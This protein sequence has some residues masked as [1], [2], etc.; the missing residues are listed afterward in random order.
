MAC[1]V[2]DNGLE[3]VM[4]LVSEQGF[5][6][7]PEAVR[8][9][10]NEAMRIERERHL[11][12]GAW[13]R[14]DERR[15]HANGYKAKT[16]RSRIGELALA[17]PQVRDSSFYPSSLERGLRSERALKLAVAEMYVTGVSTRK[18][19]RITETL[20]GFEV[21]SSEVSRCTALLDG[22]L[23][24]WRQRRFDCAYPYVL[25]D[26]RYEKVR[27]GGAVVDCAV[28]LALGVRGDGKREL[29]GA[30]VKLSEAEV[31]WRDFLTSLKDRGLCGM[32]LFVSDDHAG[33]KAARAA[34]FP[35]VPWQ[36]CQFHLQQ[37]AQAYVSR[38]EQRAPLGAEIRAI[39]NAPDDAEARRLLE[40]FVKRHEKTAPKLAQWAE[41]ALPEG[42]T[43]F[44]FP[45]DHRRRLRTSNALEGVNK[46]I[47]RRTRVATLFPNEDACLRL[48]TAVAM[49]ISE[50]WVTGKVYLQ[51][52]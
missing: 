39:F 15:G 42:F 46:Q 10:M 36:R 13:E 22:E 25:L 6:G 41:T 8:V 40:H 38:L 3:A 23:L 44:Q 20:C 7:L 1:R 45:D 28:L 27:H 17:V 2:Q 5:E 32:K 16:V 30:S 24:A 19:A 49:E 11:G 33:L 48:V 50:E 34:V 14:S 9:L 35:S 47:K 12:A 31:H 52:Q 37:N 29:L 26:A 51:M 4:E 18:V 21:S 43:V